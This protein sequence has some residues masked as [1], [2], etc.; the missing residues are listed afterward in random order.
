[1]SFLIRAL[2]LGGWAAG[3]FAGCSRSSGLTCEA[4]DGETPRHSIAWLKSQCKGASQ[5]L[6]EDIVIRGRVVANDAYG[7]W[8]R[9]LVLA[10]ETGGITIYADDAQLY[11][12]YPFGATVVLYAN[13]LRLYDYGGKVVVGSEPSEYGFGIDR[14]AIASHLQRGENLPDAPEP[15]DLSLA[16][17]AAEHIDTYVRITGVHFVEQECWCQKDSVTGRFVDTDRTVVD[18]TGRTLRIRTR[19]SCSYAKE[20]LPSGKGSM[21][22]IVDC[23][24]GRYALR[25]VNREF[26]FQT[27][28]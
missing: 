17:I 27:A 1:M 5:L 23:F 19:G 26:D 11:R 8:S 14:T 13:G 25:V 18:E 6:T 28:E 4:P 3:A 22:G 15:L 24:N 2:V 9:S 12:R 7:E 10:D 16:D 21:C 20:P